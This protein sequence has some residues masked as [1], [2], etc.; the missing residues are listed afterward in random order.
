MVEPSLTTAA[1]H[2]SPAA[3]DGSSSKTTPPISTSSPGSKPCASSARDHAH[4]AQPVLDV[5]ERLLVLEVVAREQAL[6]RVAR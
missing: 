5:R 2:R 3:Y 4:A 6:D 1:G